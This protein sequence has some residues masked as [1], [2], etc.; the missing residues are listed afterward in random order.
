MHFKLWVFC[1]QDRLLVNFLAIYFVQC[2]YIL[3]D[4]FVHRVLFYE[5]DIFVV[6]VVSADPGVLVK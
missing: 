2:L 4:C 3:F 1:A 5:C 6:V